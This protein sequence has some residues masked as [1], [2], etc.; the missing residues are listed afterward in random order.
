MAMDRDNKIGGHVSLVVCLVLQFVLTD[1]SLH[2]L[3]HFHLN[4]CS[5]EMQRNGRNGC[6]RCQD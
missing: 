5:R 6:S 3:S 1:V 4:Q 2:D